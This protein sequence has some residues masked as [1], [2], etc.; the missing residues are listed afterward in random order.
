MAMGTEA[1]RSRMKPRDG[2]IRD[3]RGGVRHAATQRI[4]SSLF[5]SSL[6][7]VPLLASVSTL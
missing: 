2:T 6:H 7:D 4:A 5:V 3:E 1:G